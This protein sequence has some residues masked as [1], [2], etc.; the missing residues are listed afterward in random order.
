MRARFCSAPQ[1][2]ARPQCDSRVTTSDRKKYRPGIIAKKQTKYRP[3]NRPRIQNELF[4]NTIK[5][6]GNFYRIK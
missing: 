5:M 4:E 2:E 3:I 1:A 6:R